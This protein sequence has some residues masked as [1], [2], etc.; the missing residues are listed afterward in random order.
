MSDPFTFLACQAHEGE[1]EMF[2]LIVFGLAQCNE[3]NFVA[4]SELFDRAFA[5][6]ET[7]GHGPAMYLSLALRIYSGVKAGD[8]DTTKHVL[9]T[10]R[11]LATG[12]EY[13]H[14]QAALDAWEGKILEAE[15]LKDLAKEKYVRAADALEVLGETDLVETIRTYLK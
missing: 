4:A 2:Y 12:N 6:A 7:N 11:R 3:N 1:D 14:C 9:E 10:A 8:W 15:N 5:D 13:A